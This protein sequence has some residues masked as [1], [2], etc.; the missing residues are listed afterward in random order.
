MTHQVQTRAKG[1]IVVLQCAT[2]F[3]AAHHLA[4]ADSTRTRVLY[5]VRTTEPIT[6]DGVLGETVWQRA[7][8]AGF[9]QRE[10]H[11]GA[12]ASEKT[13]V[14]FAYDD[15]A[16]YVAARMYDSS[17]DQIV[18]RL[19]RK[20]NGVEADWIYVA[21][22]PSFNRRTAFVF[23]VSAGGALFDGYISNDTELS[24][25]WDGVWDVD[26]ARDEHGW[27][28]EFQI[29]FSQFRFSDKPEQIWGVEFSR[30]VQRK[31]EN[32]LLVLHPLHDA[33]RVS[34]FSELHGIT[35]IHPPS[36]LE[37]L[38]YVTAVRK[39]VEAPPVHSFNAGRK[40]PFIVGRDIIGN[41]GADVKVGLTGELTLDLAVNPDFAQVEVDPAVV[42]LSAY[43]VRFAERRPF[44]VEGESILNF[45][46][47]GATSYQDYNW[48]DPSFFY[49]RRIGRRPQGRVK[50]AGFQNVPDR[51]TILGA[52]KVS[53]RISK[54][55]YIAALTALTDREY[56]EVDS[57]GVRFR[58]VVEPRT[59]YAVTRVRREMDEARQGL[60]FISTFLERERGDATLQNLLSRRA[61]SFG[62]DGWVFL[63]SNRDWVLT[64]WTGVSRVEGTTQRMISLQQSPTHYFQRP[65]A[66][67]VSIDTLA[68][69]LTGWASRIWLNKEKGNWRFNAAVGAIHPRFETNDVGFHGRTDYINGHVWGGYFSYEPDAIFRTKAIAAV[70]FREFNFGGV[71][72]GETYNL[73]LQ[74]QLLNYWGGYTVIGHNEPT[75]DDQRT[76]GGPL[77]RSLRSNFTHIGIYSDS[78]KAFN[79]SV[80][81]TL[82]KGE[83]GSDQV[84]V[85]ASV[86]WT[87]TPTLRLSGGPTYFANHNTAQYITT[88]D[89]P[90]A[91]NTFG[92][93][94]VMGTLDQRQISA[95]LRLDWT[96][97]PRISFQLY[98]Q[99]LLSTGRYTDIKELREPRTFSFNHYSQSPSSIEYNDTTSEYRIVP[100]GLAGSAFTLRN[101]DFNFKSLR[102]NAVLRW[103]YMPGSTLFFVWTNEKVDYETRGRLSFDRDVRMLLKDRPDNVFA[104]KMTYWF[105]P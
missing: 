86:S 11:E 31:K 17:P 91:T 15:H 2:L 76:R 102:A 26:V 44:F 84:V 79:G 35:G 54:S 14:W 1:C 3:F 65:D 98:I 50:H 105:H 39:F 42:N 41:V 4:L 100:L 34:R 78:R 9:I 58:D 32:S 7:G 87:P 12:P 16:L 51:T 68:T 67:H 82:A 36:R 57:A 77:M 63:D 21:I 74:A 30:E 61:V 81:T 60:G 10:P 70:A 93:R 5:A 23:G 25:S 75:F 99:P 90:A 33:V 47:G 62:L 52:A 28:A 89:D 19:A 85:G 27:T 8:T 88:R 55:W 71:Q 37:I 96:F 53:G 69:G 49:S 46:R 56:G 97:T 94:Y 20:D 13:E 73:I 24:S 83:S 104:I 103:E 80:F 29:P 72:I 22:D 64:G 66:G 18:A 48:S 101:P 6:I 92:R 95:S 45:G 40:D 38:P 43:E 59:F